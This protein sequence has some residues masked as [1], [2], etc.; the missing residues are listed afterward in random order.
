MSGPILPLCSCSQ[1]AR[2]RCRDKQQPFI[3]KNA[4]RVQEKLIGRTEVLYN[5][6]GHDYV[7]SLRLDRQIIR[8]GL[9]KGR[10]ITGRAN[11][12]DAIQRN[13]H[14]HGTKTLFKPLQEVPVA[15]SNVK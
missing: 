4:L 3:T 12:L 14:T 13:V 10:V 9:E 7:N 11:V 5:I 8:R 15:K 2:I 6:H 1:R